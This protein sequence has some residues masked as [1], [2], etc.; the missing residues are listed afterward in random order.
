MLLLLGRGWI[1]AGLVLCWDAY[2]NED[3]KSAVASLRLT[4][5]PSR[6]VLTV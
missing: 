2:R 3:L 1:D 6:Q 5:G 4:P